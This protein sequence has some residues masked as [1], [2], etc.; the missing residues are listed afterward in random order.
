MGERRAAAEA[1]Y[2][3]LKTR[4]QAAEAAKKQYGP[5]SVEYESADQAWTQASIDILESI[6]RHSNFELGQ[7]SMVLL[8]ESAEVSELVGLLD[9]Q[10]GRWRV[11]KAA[12]R[13]VSLLIPAMYGITIAVL[14]ALHV[15][16][17]A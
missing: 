4:Q 11:F 2:A 12:H 1:E 15:Y 3:A 5:G 16:K 14:M 10:V 13:A 7:R 9:E 8:R 6:E 17:L